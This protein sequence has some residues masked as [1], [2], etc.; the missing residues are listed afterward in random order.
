MVP[1]GALGNLDLYS[2]LFGL[3]WR[4]GS[5]WALDRVWVLLAPGLEGL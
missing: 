1:F 5:W 4:E 2:W 3:W